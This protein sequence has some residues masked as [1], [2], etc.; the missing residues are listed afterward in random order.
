VL[1]LYGAL[2][3]PS[4][5]NRQSNPG[6]IIAGGS[7]TLVVADSPNNLT[8]AATLKK[9]IAHATVRRTAGTV[10]WCPAGILGRRSLQALQRSMTAGSKCW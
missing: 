8:G 4:K 7:K 2:P 3:L 10:W 5:D 1:L 6:Q 9:A